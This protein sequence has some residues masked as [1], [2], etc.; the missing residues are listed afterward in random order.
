MLYHG[1]KHFLVVHATFAETKQKI[2]IPFGLGDVLPASTIVS[3]TS[4]RAGVLSVGGYTGNS[5]RDIAWLSHEDAH[6]FYPD[7][8][9]ADV[10][11]PYAFGQHNV[12]LSSY[13]P[14]LM[15]SPVS[16][17][18]IDHHEDVSSVR[19]GHAST[20]G[21]LCGLSA[22]SIH[23]A[24]RVISKDILGMYDVE[25]L[26]KKNDLMSHLRAQ[27]TA[28]GDK[29]DEMAYESGCSFLET[30]GEFPSVFAVPPITPIG[31]VSVCSEFF[32]ELT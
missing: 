8:A 30:R 18:I 11:T 31:S 7:D 1:G 15:L 14:D 19:T 6:F 24:A 20:G 27:E 28:L 9:L 2:D 29:M 16:T 3:D 17:Y 23:S 10:W 25:Y 12:F 22:S 4:Q 13:Y 5:P 26:E 21:H 32:V